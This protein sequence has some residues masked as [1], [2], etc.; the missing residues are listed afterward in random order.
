MLDTFEVYGRW[1]A[2]DGIGSVGLSGPQT[3]EISVPAA[4]GGSKP[5][6]NPEELLL[7]SALSCYLMTLGRLLQRR[8][9]ATLR[10][11]ASIAGEVGRTPAGLHFEAIRLRPVVHLGGGGDAARQGA[12]LALAD[13]EEACFIA[14]T[15][16][17][18]I[19]YHLEPQFVD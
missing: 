2:T 9:M 7:A 19:P 15:L 12:A 10:V 11:E 14:R 6:T 5:G 1:S 4:F 3:A 17:P 8:G 18:V 16:R 13:A